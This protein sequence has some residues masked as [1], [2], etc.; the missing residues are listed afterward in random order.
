MNHS[1]V[2]LNR[3]LQEAKA[4]LVRAERENRHVH[5]KSAIAH[6]ITELEAGIHWLTWAY[7][8][9]LEWVKLWSKVEEGSRHVQEVHSNGRKRDGRGK[10][11]SGRAVRG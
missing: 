4:A 3:A 1:L 6:N 8:E 9:R 10:R 5:Y 11:R 2:V 7:K